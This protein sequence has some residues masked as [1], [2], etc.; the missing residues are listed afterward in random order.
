VHLAFTIPREGSSFD[1]D[2]LLI[3]SQAPHLTAAHRFLNYMLEPRVIAAR[4]ART[5]RAAAR[6]VSGA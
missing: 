1:Y 4:T 6:T 3:S 2:A 5:A